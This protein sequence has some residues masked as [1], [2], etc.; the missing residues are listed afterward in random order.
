MKV[1]RGVE[2]KLYSFFNLVARWGGWLT[3]RFGRFTSWK[4]IRYPLYRRLDGTQGPSGRVRKNAPP[5]GFDPPTVQLAASQMNLCS[6]C[7]M[8]ENCLLWVKYK[9]SIMNFVAHIEVLY[10]QF[11]TMLF[12]RKGL[13]LPDSS[14]TLLCLEVTLLYVSWV[15]TCQMLFFYLLWRAS[16]TRVRAA[17]LRR[18]LDHTQ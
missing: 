15:C 17:C 11:G 16:P 5:P 10:V 14:V 13:H 6:Q 7:Q 12:H 4:E 8:S 3:P 18:F 1:Q 9:C 2:V